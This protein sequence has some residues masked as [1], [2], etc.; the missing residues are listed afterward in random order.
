MFIIFF[1]L[2]E[3]WW[4]DFFRHPR[5]AKDFGKKS[6][7]WIFEQKFIFLL[8]SWETRENFRDTQ[9]VKDFE[10]KI[11]FLDFRTKNYFFVNELGNAGEFPRYPTS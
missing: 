9:L 1:L 7:F 11:E 6:A 2:A 5:S 3:R 8:T 4:P 10:K